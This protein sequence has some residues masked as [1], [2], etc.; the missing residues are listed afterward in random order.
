M[1]CIINFT[2]QTKYERM[3]GPKLAGLTL[4]M[5]QATVFKV[6]EDA[7]CCTDKSMQAQEALYFLRDVVQTFFVNS[8]EILGLLLSV[9]QAQANMHFD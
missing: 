9:N 5:I 4:K 6:T 3:Q 1:H 2:V 8:M 7:S